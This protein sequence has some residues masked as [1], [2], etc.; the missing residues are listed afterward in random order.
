MDTCKLCGHSDYLT[1]GINVI[2]H[3]QEATD[4]E[5]FCQQYIICRCFDDVMVL[6]GDEET[7]NSFVEKEDWRNF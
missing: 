5:R 6:R 7:C 2:E 1:N 4:V 3:R